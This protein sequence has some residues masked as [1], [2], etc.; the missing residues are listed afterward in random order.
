MSPRL[1]DDRTYLVVGGLG[2]IG[3]AVIKLLTKLGAK[4]IF[5][6]S[7]SGAVSSAQ[8]QF[9]VKMEQ[10]GINIVVHKGS[11]GSLDSILAVKKLAGSQLIAGVIQGAMALEVS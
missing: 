1:R 10:A 9:L 3:R 5:T 8:K 2:G 4:N 11:V 6:L 7:R